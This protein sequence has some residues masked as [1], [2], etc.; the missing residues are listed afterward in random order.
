MT[1]AAITDAFGVYVSG[2]KQAPEVDAPAGPGL[3]RV[4]PNVVFFGSQACSP[5]S[6]RRWSMVCAAN[7]WAKD[8]V[9]GE[10]CLT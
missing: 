1:S 4:A 5:T 2:R 8:P 9:T 3:R 10:V 7:V 6:P